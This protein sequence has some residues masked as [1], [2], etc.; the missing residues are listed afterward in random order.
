MK[1]PAMLSMLICKLVNLEK[2]FVACAGE[3]EQRIDVQLYVPI[4]FVATIIS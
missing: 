2:L 3:K 4:K 1:R